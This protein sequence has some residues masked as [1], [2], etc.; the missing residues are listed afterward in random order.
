MTYFTINSHAK[1]D[2]GIC[3][4]I[5]LG[6]ELICFGF[7]P[8][9]GVAQSPNPQNDWFLVS[10]PI[11]VA[12]ALL[13]AMSTQMLLA[14]GQKVSRGIIRARSVV[15]RLLAWL[16]LAGIAFPLLAFWFRCFHNFLSQL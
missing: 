2:F 8:F 7:F 10:I 14:S 3:L 5:W 16:G 11:G 12:G 13:F 9:I 4:G 15:G 6:L 1:R